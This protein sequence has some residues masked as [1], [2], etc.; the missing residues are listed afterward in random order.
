MKKLL[1]TTVA[2]LAL[3]ALASPTF[4]DEGGTPGGPEGQGQAAD[5]ASGDNAHGRGENSRA[6]VGIGGGQSQDH[7]GDPQDGRGNDHE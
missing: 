4:A 2:V 1:V 5:A 3:S 6:E 7:G